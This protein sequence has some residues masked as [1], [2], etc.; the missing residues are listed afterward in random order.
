MEPSGKDNEKMAK[1]DNEAERHWQ[2][3]NYQFHL[4]GRQA[5]SQG[6]E[7]VEEHCWGPMLHKE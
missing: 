1:T 6:K 3:E 2:I 5:D 7:E 4:G